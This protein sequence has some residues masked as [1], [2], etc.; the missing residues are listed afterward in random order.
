MRPRKRIAP[1]ISALCIALSSAMANF[2]YANT[3]GQ[4]KAIDEKGNQQGSEEKKRSGQATERL[5][6]LGSSIGTLGLNDSSSTASRLG[7]TAMET[8]ATIEVIDAQLMRARGYTKL[9]DSLQNL[10]GVVTGNHPTAPSTFSMRGFSR[11]Q[12]T[13]L[14]DGL[15]IGPSTMVMRPQ[16]TFNLE[17]VEVLRGTA[18]VLNGVGSVGGTVNA[19]TKTAK[20]GIQNNTNVQMGYGSFNSS[21]VG[22][23]SQGE[24]SENLW[25]TL[26]LSR[27]ASDGYVDDTDSDSN[28]F[29][30]SLYWQA[31][32]DL[33]LKFSADYLEDNVGSYYGTP[34]VPATVAKDPLKVIKTARGEVIDGAM[35]DINYNVDD[36][37]AKSDQLFLRA[38]AY[39]QLSDNA[40][41]EYSVFNFGAD[42]AWQNAEGYVYCAE[43]VGTCT[44]EGEIQRYYGY[45]I[46]DHEQDV[47]GHRATIN[48][49]ND[50]GNMEN[51]FVAGIEAID[52]DFVRSRGFR[53][54]VAQVTGDGIDP[55][56]PISGTYGERELRGVSPTDIKTRAAFFGD[57]LKVT[58][59]LTL[60]ANARYEEMALV[61]ENF[62]AEGVNEN[63]GFERD[64][65]WVS[66]RVGGVYNVNE[67]V[68]AYMQY[69]DAKDPIN[70]NILLVNANQDFDLT[71][72]T[73]F[74]VGLKGSWL[75]GRVESTFA[76]FDI[77]RD[78]ILE[79]FALDSVTNVGGRSS[80]GIEVSS[81]FWLN[82]DWRLSVNAA[83]TDAEFQRSANF[84]SFAENTPP[85]V[86]E[87]TANLFTSVN[88]IAGLPVEIGASMHFVDDRFGDNANTVTLNSYTL[89]N[90]FAVYRGDNY[91]LT[92]N[93]D[94]VF[95]QNYVP[96]S[97]VFYLHQDS[98]GFIY[99]NQLLLGAP[100]SARLMF[101]YQF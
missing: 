65:D 19:I 49:N 9:S 1:Q 99:A 50:I 60:V 92:L 76:Y 42:R 37:Y 78:D 23:G 41:L 2:A 55:Y 4:V 90:L 21:H 97:D 80:Q 70:S 36:A 17:R 67:E 87:L 79:R 53:R 86:P 69:S 101:D 51:R 7:L 52:L 12:I 64:Y 30:A 45:F 13:V 98:P 39:W 68:M 18:S 100:R 27:Y 54:Q 95:D 38:D 5:V 61:R 58:P 85:N 44:Q 84:E 82:D 14:R 73:Q 10:P 20:P 46:L 3:D 47:L 15:W 16:N 66:W 94:N 29:T 8:P 71:D 83:Y 31:S 26:D 22:L 93:V 72:A 74:E 62:N 81:S 63:N 40:R 96:W 24:L 35:R 33:G 56:Q 43:V 32:D 75:N 48:I 57:A 28:N 34:L 88:N 25:Y 77:E 11:G 89:T 6:V 59:D 91:R